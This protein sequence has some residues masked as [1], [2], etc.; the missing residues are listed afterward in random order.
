MIQ[1]M[2]L[3]LL[4]LTLPLGATASS[5]QRV[6]PTPSGYV[7]SLRVPDIEI[8]PELPEL[9]FNDD[10][11]LSVERVVEVQTAKGQPVDDVLVEFQVGP[12][13]VQST[14]ISPQRTI[15]RGGK[16]RVVLQTTSFDVVRILVRVDH[17]ALE[18]SIAVAKPLRG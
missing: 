13:W 12:E 14:W 16:V 17:T 3:S 18:A 11:P 5:V 1:S 15:T 4:C 7:F 2:L 9:A 10:L 8:C 6:G